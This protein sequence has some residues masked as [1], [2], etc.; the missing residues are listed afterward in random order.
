MTH[1]NEREHPLMAALKHPREAFLGFREFRSGVGMTYEDAR[2]DAYDL[3]RDLAHRLTLRRW[4]H[5]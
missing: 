2:D 1:N 5:C 4:D 3:G